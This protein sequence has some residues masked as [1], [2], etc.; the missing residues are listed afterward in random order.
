MERQKETELEWSNY[1]RER[2][3]LRTGTGLLWSALIGEGAALYAVG[4]GPSAFV[5]A[6]CLISLPVTAVMTLY[7]FIGRA[8]P[9]KPAEPRSETD[10][11]H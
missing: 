11:K 7:L 1:H 3:L 9:E 8:S 6:V 4:Y 10:V 5:G 2:M